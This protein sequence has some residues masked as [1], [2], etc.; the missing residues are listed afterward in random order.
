METGLTTTT[1]PRLARIDQN[2]AAVYLAGLSEGSR[3]TMRHALDSVAAM[4]DPGA[5]AMT[6]SWP[7]L[8]YQHVAA[9]RSRLAEQY[10][11]ATVN[12]RLSAVRGVLK[13][14]WRLGL[15]T[16]ETYH[17]AVDVANVKGERL[18]AGRALS[19][20]ELAALFGACAADAV[21]VRDAAMLA[22]LYCGGLR[23]AELVALDFADFEPESGALDVRRGKR[24][25]QRTV[26]VTN[27]ALVA[28]GRWLEL[29]GA[30]PGALFCGVAQGGRLQ[31]GRLTSQTVYDVLRKLATRAGL[32]HVTP[33]DLR[34]TFVGDL[35]DAGADLSTVQRLAGHADPNTTARYDRRPERAKADAAARLE[36]PF[37]P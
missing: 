16:A 36:A 2:P 21:G 20:G 34:R 33:H 3:R 29:R 14:A 35:L 8:R 30:E 4:I 31:R 5:D 19:K 11:P 28:L 6:L 17:R 10:A 1:Q 24:N 27:G 7:A 25:K 23:R 9:I 12:K 37:S 22:V 32:G 15:M 18:P 26:Y 13:A